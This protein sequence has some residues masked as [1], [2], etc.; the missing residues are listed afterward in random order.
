[1][2]QTS[3]YKWSNDNSTILRGIREKL[4]HF[5]DKLSK[6]KDV[7]SVLELALWK[8]KMNGFTLEE[9]LTRHQKK[10]KTNQSELQQQ[11][12]VTCGADVVIGHVLPF[13]ITVD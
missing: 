13:L 2:I 11:C 7:T 1:M 5:E 4:A 6:L 3:D 12:R 9:N 10:I 8:M